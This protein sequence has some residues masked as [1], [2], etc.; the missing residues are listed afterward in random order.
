MVVKIAMFGGETMDENVTTTE[1]HYL[2]MCLYVLGR[3]AIF[4]LWGVVL[5]G[6][7][8]PVLLLT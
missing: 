2:D 5:C 3:V 4:A 6:V 1:P 7:L 8:V